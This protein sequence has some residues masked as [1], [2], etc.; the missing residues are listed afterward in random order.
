MDRIRARCDSSATSTASHL[1]SLVAE[2]KM[3][4]ERIFKYSNILLAMSVLFCASFSPIVKGPS[5][6]KH[7][8]CV[9]PI[10]FMWVNF[11]AG[12]PS[13][14][15]SFLD[16]LSSNRDYEALIGDLALLKALP[17]DISVR[18]IGFTDSRECSGDA[19]MN[20]SLRRAKALH[21]WL[22][23]QGIPTSRLGDPYGFGNARPVGD[24]RTKDGRARNRRAY[25]SYEGV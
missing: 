12:K 20:L 16:S 2:R 3:R 18:V 23:D 19:C 1:P 11:K 4:Q 15:G 22:I 13:H 5:D 10:D 9:S 25:I 21:D 14:G 24:N 17:L 8:Y 6:D 7:G